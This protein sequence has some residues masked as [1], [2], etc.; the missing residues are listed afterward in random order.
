MI[1]EP[2]PSP[3][4]PARPSR[5]PERLSKA[6]AWLRKGHE[7]LAGLYLTIPVFVLYHVGILFVST[8]NG[9]DLVSGVTLR[10]LH[11]SKPAYV[12][13]TL[14]VAV[15]LIVAVRILRRTSRL[16]VSE[17]LPML[18]ESL[19]FAFV[20]PFAAGWATQKLFAWELGNHSMD[21]FEKLVMAAGAG[22]HEEVLFRVVL[23]GG[24]VLLFE[25]VL[26]LSVTKAALLAALLSALAF[27]SV[28]YVGPF[29]DDLTL[30]SFS[31]RALSGVL[32]A[33]LYWWRGFA[34][35]VYTHMFYDLMV[36]FLV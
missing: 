6:R 30:I 5:R 28:H 12:A 4:Q 14:A 15:G 29:A 7:P 33:A 35:A 10:L 27:S 16:Q 3:S 23:F 20:V 18:G 13:V 34:V 9:A 19:V 2:S 11:S 1:S 8:R 26:K 22:F 21:A 24:L 36:F 25:R 31:F 17:W 32:L